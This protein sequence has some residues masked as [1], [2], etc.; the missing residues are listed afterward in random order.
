[1]P[2]VLCHGTLAVGP[3]AHRGSSGKGRVHGFPSALHSFQKIFR[4]LP[5]DFRQKLPPDQ[6]IIYYKKRNSS[7]K[8]VPFSDPASVAVT[9]PGSGGEGSLPMEWGHPAHGDDVRIRPVSP[10]R[11]FSFRAPS[12]A[13]P[14][15]RYWFP[16]E[17]LYPVR[18]G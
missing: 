3:A 15:H 10:Q 8:R 6:E 5:P 11:D 14:E 7:A 17:P 13:V 1:M 2:L 4:D 18:C 12:S 16:E 9:L